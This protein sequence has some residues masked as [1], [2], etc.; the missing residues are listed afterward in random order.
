MAIP[1]PLLQK[2]WRCFYGPL[3]YRPRARRCA[4]V[5]DGIISR[6][7]DDNRWTGCF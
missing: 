4:H 2:W 5:P 7:N 1:L 3:F 6:A